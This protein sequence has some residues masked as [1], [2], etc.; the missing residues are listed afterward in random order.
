MK[1]IN[2]ENKVLKVKPIKDF[3]DVE[4]TKYKNNTYIIKIENELYFVINRKF[5]N[6]IIR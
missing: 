5:T 6:H 4:M 3:A 1:I 2:K